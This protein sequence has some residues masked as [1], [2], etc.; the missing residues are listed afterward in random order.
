MTTEPT[1]P[2]TREQRA[3]LVTARETIRLALAGA[4]HAD[5][6]AAGRQLTTCR[7]CNVS[8]FEPA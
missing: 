8:W 5:L 3:D 7:R 4:D 2:L 1:H 6:G